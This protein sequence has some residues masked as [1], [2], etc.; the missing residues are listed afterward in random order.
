MVKLLATNN[1]FQEISL[2]GS[3]FSRMKK[4]LHAKF[5]VVANRKDEII[6]WLENKIKIT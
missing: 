2:L 5:E 4:K 3:I 6:K 1:V